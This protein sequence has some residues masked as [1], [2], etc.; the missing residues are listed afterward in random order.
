MRASEIELRTVKASRPTAFDHT[1]GAFSAFE[2][3]GD[4]LVC[5]CSRTRDSGPL[6]ESNWHV[7]IENLRKIDNAGNDHETH[8]IGHWGPGWYEIAI[9][10]PGSA[11]HLEAQE[12]TCALADHPVLSDEDY[13][14]REWDAAVDAYSAHALFKRALGPDAIEWIRQRESDPTAVI[15]ACAGYTEIVDGAFRLCLNAQ[16]PEDRPRIA[17]IVRRIRRKLRATVAR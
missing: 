2:D 6:E 11:C 16:H 8:R 3:R 5:P 13:S 17:E 14:A 10:R 12:L 15:D 1:L 7:Q 9:V 4:W